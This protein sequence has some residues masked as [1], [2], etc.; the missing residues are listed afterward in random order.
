MIAIIFHSLKL[1]VYNL[2]PRLDY[3]VLVVGSSRRST[4]LA[5][6]STC[7]FQFVTST[8]NLLALLDGGDGH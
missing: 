7:A 1:D 2:K 5:K 8:S 6:L 3:L 4:D